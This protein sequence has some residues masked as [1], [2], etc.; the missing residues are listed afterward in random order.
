M[1]K[2]GKY[3]I[4]SGC[5][6]L[7]LVFPACDEYLDQTP[8]AKI[9]EETIFTNYNGFQGFFDQCYAF[10]VDYTFGHS[11]AG[12]MNFAGESVCFKDWSSESQA[13]IGDYYKIAGITSQTS[14]FINTQANNPLEVSEKNVKGIFAGGWRGIRVA[15]MALA[16]LGM[17]TDATQEQ[18]RLIEGQAYFFRAFFYAEMVKA[19]G[20]LPYVDKFLSAE[21]DLNLPRLS[22]QETTEKIV[23]DFDRAADLLPEDWD[24]TEMGSK[25]LGANRGRATRGAALAFKARC[26]LYAGSPLMNYQQSG[27]YSFD[28][29]YMIRAAEAAYEVI[30]LADKG[31][32]SL[33]D[34]S[35]Y[36]T[37]F[38]RNDGAY[39]WT[40]E[41]IFQR[42]H[43][44]DPSWLMGRHGARFV[45]ARFGFSAPVHTPTQ[46]LIDQ[47]G[48][49]STG[50]PIDD[51]GSGYDPMDPWSD[52]DPRLRGGI[53]V[54]GDMWTK[55]DAEENKLELYKGGIDDYQEVRTPYICKKYWPL[56]MNNVDQEYGTYYGVT[57]HI[58]LAEIYIIYAEAVNEAFGPTGTANGVSLTAADALNKVRNRAG[59]PDIPAKFLSDRDSF[60][61]RI[62]EEYSVEFFL[63]GHR[64]FDIRRWHVAHLPEYKELYTLEFDKDHTY[65]N[66]KLLTTR[67]FDE[68]HYWLPFPPEQT[69]IYPGFYQNPGW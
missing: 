19:Y 55:K 12:T 18:K 59:M 66:R 36:Y 31:V 49:Q 34:F 20:G 28:I 46:N 35:E 9:S 23:Q 61:Q 7:L 58:R 1:K 67:V 14:N 4:I 13:E 15:N 40:D 33:T 38:A 29:D 25:N 8:D 45:P 5:I 37:M 24:D 51:P 30:K 39:P 42:V 68:K 16:K 21:D 60:R 69:N 41:T 47:F 32:Y 2:T 53:L 65:F 22:Y 56:G 48:V 43:L 6:C 27:N 52:R 3:L 62:W 10:I 57:P 50:L 26:L 17:L 54:D 11:H 44:F 64:W 63:E